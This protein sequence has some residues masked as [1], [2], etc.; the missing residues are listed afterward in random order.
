[1][2]ADLPSIP[3]DYIW[4]GAFGVVGRLMFHA[5]EVQRGKRKPLSWALLT[6][7][8][9]ALGMGWAAYGVSVWA[10]L[11]FQPTMSASMLAAYLGPYTLDLVFSRAAEKYFGGSTK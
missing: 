2:M 1:M 5:R 9:I 4:P 3:S 8:P 6:D 10:H 7:L 11:S